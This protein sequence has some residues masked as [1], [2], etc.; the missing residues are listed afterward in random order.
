MCVGMCRR[1]AR[2]S[3]CA[4]TLQGMSK[5]GPA[6][7][8][9]KLKMQVPLEC[10]FGDGTTHELR[11]RQAALRSLLA[12]ALADPPC[13]HEL[14]FGSPAQHSGARTGHSQE[15]V[16]HAQKELAALAA[17]AH[18]EAKLRTQLADSR[19]QADQQL[20]AV[21]E[22]EDAAAQLQAALGASRAELAASQKAA[23]AVLRRV[24]LQEAALVS[25]EKS[26]DAT[27]L[28]FGGARKA[29]LA[30]SKELEMLKT[31]IVE[32]WE[33]TEEQQV[34]LAA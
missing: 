23:S 21:A 27:R 11:A 10:D 8:R 24:E 25:A 30:A 17:L 32:T 29:V 19:T 5:A 34:A 20:K 31:T 26:L 13:V 1:G 2:M 9:L 14:V 4:G 12:E 7:L 33:A 28:N 22:K 6:R 16:E 3:A 15:E 18:E